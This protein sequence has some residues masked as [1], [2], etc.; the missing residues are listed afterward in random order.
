MGI[1]HAG[2]DDDDGRA[3]TG[4]RNGKRISIRLVTVGWTEVELATARA[5]RDM[6][7]A[8]AEDGVDLVVRSGFRSHDKQRQLYERW[9][10]GRGNLAAKPGYSNHQAGSAL[11]I[12]MN[13]ASFPWLTR[14]ARAFG[15]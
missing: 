5:F 4:Y 6:Q 13:E 11:D 10:A 7:A 3:A 2:N 9:R 8:A 12:V 1:A 14:H 15:F